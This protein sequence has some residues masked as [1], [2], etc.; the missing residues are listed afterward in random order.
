MSK[1]FHTVRYPH[2]EKRNML[3]LVSKAWPPDLR[4]RQKKFQPNLVLKRLNLKRLGL[5]NGKTSVDLKEVVKFFSFSTKENFLSLFKLEKV[6][7]K[8]K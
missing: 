2:P 4:F 8:K 5:I 7:E 6:K 3:G 1:K